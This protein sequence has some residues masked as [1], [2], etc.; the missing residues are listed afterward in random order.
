MTK[1]ERIDGLPSSLKELT[2]SRNQIIDSNIYFGWSFTNLT[3]ID[4]IDGTYNDIPVSYEY[5]LKMKELNI[6][7]ENVAY[8]GNDRNQ[9]G[10]N[11]PEIVKSISYYHPDN[12]SLTF[13]TLTYFFW[14]FFG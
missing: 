4:V 5:H 13:Y 1:I 12:Y 2:L 11:I 8:N 6:H 7:Y 10:E 9:Y 14:L 3:K